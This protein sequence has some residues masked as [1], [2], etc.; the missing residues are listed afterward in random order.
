MMKRMY[1]LLCG[2]IVLSVLIP[3]TTS[4]QDA[5]AEFGPEISDIDWLDPLSPQPFCLYAQFDAG[6][7]AQDMGDHP[8][9]QGRRRQVMAQQKRRPLEQFRMLKMLELLDL[10]EDQELVFMQAFRAVRKQQADLNFQKA[11]L[12][13]QLGTGIHTGQ[14]TDDQIYEMVQSLTA[15]KDEKTRVVQE[16]LSSAREFL[17]AEQFGKLVL[18]SE[19]FE[20]EILDQVR[21]FRNR[22]RSGQGTAPGDDEGP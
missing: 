1:T 17:T 22:D 4:G 12:L 5:V 3:L 11:E 6:R 19:R 18:F 2:I 21:A 9:R 7:H 16:F 10:A 8:G 13:R 20:Q 15:L 14:L